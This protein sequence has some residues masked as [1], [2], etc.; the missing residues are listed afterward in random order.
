MLRK[1]WLVAEMKGLDMGQS[2]SVPP[3][4]GGTL[5]I[6]DLDLDVG[7][8]RLTIRGTPDATVLEVVLARLLR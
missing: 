4:D 3:V 5:G 8:A 6:I 7:K 1:K 2:K